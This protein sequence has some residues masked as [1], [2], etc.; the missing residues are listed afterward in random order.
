MITLPPAP[1]SSAIHHWRSEASEFI[2]TRTS[3]QENLTSYN[4]TSDIFW[5]ATVFEILFACFKKQ[6]KIDCCLREPICV[7]NADQNV[8]VYHQGKLHLKTSEPQRTSSHQAISHSYPAH[9][10]H[11]RTLLLSPRHQKLPFVEFCV[12]RR[13]LSG[14]FPEFHIPSRGFCLF[15][16]NAYVKVAV[17]EC[18]LSHGI[19]ITFSSIKLVHPSHPRVSS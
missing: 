18:F 14:D 9:V 8:S 11:V 5:P 10:D 3:T 12:S 19:L 7:N 4:N 13:P 17:F 6:S 16:L 15:H 2:K 1:L